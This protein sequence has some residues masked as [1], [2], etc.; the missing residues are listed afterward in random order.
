MVDKADCVAE[1]VSALRQFADYLEDDG[2]MAV[3]DAEADLFVGVASMLGDEGFRAMV[4]RD[5][6]GVVWRG[7]ELPRD[8]ELWG[9]VLC[10][11]CAA[12]A[13]FGFECR[14]GGSERGAKRGVVVAPLP[15]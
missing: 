4:G 14:G 8:G 7:E 5:V 1:F 10:R 12:V 15:R 3:I 2:G 11:F 13:E 9:R 6:G